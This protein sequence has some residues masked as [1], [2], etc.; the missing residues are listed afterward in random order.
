MNK[1]SYYILFLM[2]FLLSFT[3]CVGNVSLNIYDTTKDKYPIIYSMD[4]DSFY[5]FINNKTIDYLEKTVENGTGKKY[6]YIL[7]NGFIDYVDLMDSDNTLTDI[8]FNEGTYIIDDEYFRFWKKNNLKKLIKKYLNEDINIDSFV[9]LRVFNG[10]DTGGELIGWIK[11]GNKNYFVT[12]NKSL[13]KNP[14]FEKYANKHYYINSNYNC[15]G[16][17][18]EEKFNEK[19]SIKKAVLYNKNRKI[20]DDK[21]TLIRYGYAFC[22]IDKFMECLGFST[23]WIDSEHLE[24]TKGE[25]TSYMFELKSTDNVFYVYCLKNG[26]KLSDSNWGFVYGRIINGKY[27]ITSDSFEEILYTF[28]GSFSID[29]DKNII[30]VK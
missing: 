22:P 17:Y 14:F 28:K 8:K 3:G 1:K 23:K 11:S 7:K 16:V 30:I 9:I 6:M 26:I 20:V 13:R 5:K 25:D 2:L 12:R 21:N 10:N 15:I 18:N 19:Y 29:Y 27:L 4:I 24:I